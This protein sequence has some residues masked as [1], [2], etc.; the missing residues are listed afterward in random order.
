VSPLDLLPAVYLIVGTT[1]AGVMLGGIV[2]A[3]LNL[4]DIRRTGHASA[5]LA[6]RGWS[7]SCS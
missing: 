2:D 3:A 1:A 5:C 6:P 7:C 4:R